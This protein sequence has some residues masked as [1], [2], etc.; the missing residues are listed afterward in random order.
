MAYE[1][2]IKLGGLWINETKDGEKYFNGKL[3]PTTKV[4]IFKNKYKDTENHPDY[5]MYLAAN[6]KPEDQNTDEPEPS[7]PSEEG[8]NSLPF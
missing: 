5:I 6:K 2:L 3:S 7:E 4:M 8:G 1:G